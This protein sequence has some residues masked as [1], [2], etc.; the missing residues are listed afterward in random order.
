MAE[1]HGSTGGCPWTC[2]CARLSPTAGRSPTLFLESGTILVVPLAPVPRD[3]ERR[4]EEEAVAGAVDVEAAA[5][6]AAPRCR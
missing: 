1:Q 4:Q 6:G 3:A 2:T 5:A